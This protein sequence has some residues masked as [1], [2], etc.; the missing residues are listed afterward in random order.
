[1]HRSEVLSIINSAFKAMLE[2]DLIEMSSSLP[3][4][5]NDERIFSLLDA[6]SA[7]LDDT[8]D[9]SAAML[10][11]KMERLSASDVDRVC[12][13]F[14]VFYLFISSLMIGINPMLGC[15]P[16]SSMHAPNQ[17]QAQEGKPS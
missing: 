16:L 4:I 13:A 1:M 8:I 6:I 15:H 14:C 5:E 10:T 9:S 11:S 17:W 2:R 7:G 3:F 12:S